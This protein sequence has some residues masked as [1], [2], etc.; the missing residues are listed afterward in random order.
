MPTSCLQYSPSNW[1]S[2][3]SVQPS[4]FSP[5][6]TKARW[7]WQHYTTLAYIDSPW[8]H[9]F[10]TVFLWFCYGFPHETP[11]FTRFQQPFGSLTPTRRIS[12]SPGHAGRLKELLSEQGADSV[13]ET[14]GR[15]W[16]VVLGHLYGTCFWY[17]FCKKTNIGDEKWGDF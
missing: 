12:W 14:L 7:E 2:G 5:P 11:H 16:R 13:M 9:N 3:E 6:K 1:S 10:P 8:N 4:S 15:D 17:F